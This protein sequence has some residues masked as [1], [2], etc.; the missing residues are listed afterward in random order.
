[1]SET[2]APPVTIMEFLTAR[3][4]EDE[5][6]AT[7]ALGNRWHAQGNVELRT[8][9]GEEPHWAVIA[10]GPHYAQDWHGHDLRPTYRHLARHDPAHVLRDIAAKRALLDWIPRDV[11]YPLASVYSDH[12]DYREEWR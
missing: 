1:M 7:A 10:N 4:D 2:T 5:A 9:A 11:E 8:E 12:P 3:L 6:I